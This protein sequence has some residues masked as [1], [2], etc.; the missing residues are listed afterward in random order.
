MAKKTQPSPQV[1]TVTSSKIYVSQS[2]AEA[3]HEK[4]ATENIIYQFGIL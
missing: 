3:N 2:F 4:K 1:K